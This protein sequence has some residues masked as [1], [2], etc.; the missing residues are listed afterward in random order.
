MDN[1]TWVDAAR[2]YSVMSENDRTAYWNSL[3]ADQRDMLLQALDAKRVP[4]ASDVQARRSGCGRAVRF[5]CFGIIL[6]VVLVIGAEVTMFYM[7]VEAITTPS[8]YL[9]DPEP[10]DCKGQ[11][12]GPIDSNEPIYAP[13]ELPEDCQEWIKRHQQE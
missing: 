12:F 1:N 6:G 11:A 10:D 4:S 13:S 5:G 3:S 8:A 9:S 2:N 7:G